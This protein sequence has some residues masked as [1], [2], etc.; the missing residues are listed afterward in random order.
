ME[1]CSEYYCLNIIVNINSFSSLCNN[2]NTILKYYCKQALNKELKLMGGAMK[3]FTKKNYWAMKYFTK[4]LLGHEIL[5][6]M[7]P[8]GHEIISEKNVYL[9]Y[10]P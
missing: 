8:W 10:I 5:S 1:N 2:V 4:K 7:T 6:S 3:Y 9:M